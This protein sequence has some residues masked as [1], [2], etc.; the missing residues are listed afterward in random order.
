M[1]TLIALSAVLM[2]HP[3][4]HTAPPAPPEVRT[5]VM[6]MG[7]DG[8]GGLDRDGDGQITREEF[9]APM[10]DHFARMDKDGDGRLSTDELTAGH[11]AMAGAHGGHDVMIRR[12]PGGPGHHGGPGAHMMPPHGEG[13]SGERIEIRRMGG[14]GGE[15]DLDAD[16]DGRISEAE[17]SAPLREAF[18]RLDADRS[19]F[20]EA[21]ER[22][23]G[24]AEVF[25]HRMETR[26]GDED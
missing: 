3:P 6:V 8:P 24:H 19:G 23:S 4:A 14:P 22:G 7:G 18:M 11:A 1:L 15:H 9:A 17:F 5:R 21:G 2:Q 12:G 16:D 25:V 20:I 26:S 13:G 10:N